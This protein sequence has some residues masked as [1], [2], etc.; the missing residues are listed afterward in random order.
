M[1]GVRRRTLGLFLPN[2][3]YRMN[4]WVVFYIALTLESILFQLEN[5]AAYTGI[6]RQPWNAEIANL[7]ILFWIILLDPQTFDHCSATAD[8]TFYVL[9]IGSTGDHHRDNRYLLRFFLRR[10]QRAT[11]PFRVAPVDKEF[12]KPLNGVHFVLCCLFCATLDRY[13]QRILPQPSSPCFIIN[14]SST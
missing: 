5:A 12:L 13:S 6:E 3:S 4:S 2:S 1:H 10:L 8:P 11:P 7:M 9:Y 14:C